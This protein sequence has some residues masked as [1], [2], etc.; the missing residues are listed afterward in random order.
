MKGCYFLGDEESIICSNCNSKLD[1]IKYKRNFN[2]CWKCQHHFRM[3]TND[4]IK[5]V[6]DEN[7]VV[8]FDD[9]I[10]TNDPLMFP[11][12]KEKLDKAQNDNDLDSAV[13]T[14]I[15]KIQGQLVYFTL[16][17]Y[18]FMMGSVGIV[19]GEK[20]TRVFE[21]AI[22]D[23][24]PIL[25][26]TASGGI[27]IQEGTVALYQMIKIATQI[28]KLNDEGLLF[29]SIIT[30]P[31]FGGVAASMA[32]L[33]DLVISEPNTTV[34][35]AGRRVVKQVVKDNLEQGFQTSE[36]MYKHGFLDCIVERK[37]LKKVLANILRLHNFNIS[38]ITNKCPENHTYS[39]TGF[40]VNNYSPWE[41]VKAVR[42]INRPR[43]KDY[44]KGMI[45]DF[46]ELH[47]DRICND[48][49]ALVCG[50]GFLK[51]LPVTIIGTSRGREIYENI[52]MNFGSPHPEGYRKAL[53]AM[54]QAEKFNR[55]IL[56]FIDTPG[57]A[58]DLSAEQG[59]QAEAIA[60]C[61]YEMSSIRVPIISI[62]H[63]EGG[64]GGALALTCSDYTY[65]MENS[66]FSVIS[67]ESGAIIIYKDAKKAEEISHDLKFTADDLLKLGVIDC[68]LTE[69]SIDENSYIMSVIR[70]TVYEKILDT[71]KYSKDEL[72]NRRY[73]KIRNI[74]IKG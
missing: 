43:F 50:I 37:K 10:H 4:R 64:S 58:C 47:G 69:P 39:N 51:N 28:K 68:I 35:F 3:N 71:F 59:G 24:L 48:D 72:I 19:E 21:K 6:F 62:I 46:I 60:R 27:R 31:T 70:D 30:D 61:L 54:K 25:V 67:P 17:D 22:N 65:M 20:I 63:G 38:N 11:K 73:S 52:E 15:G 5:L 49:K 55:P 12:Y 26:F 34:G 53:R 44:L 1:Y 32:F 74:G 14:G 13:K 23:R 29:I 56:C 2:V 40:R 18:R 42:S 45:T 36:F 8:F 16:F 41:K 7:S 66:I 9:N 57:A 33:G